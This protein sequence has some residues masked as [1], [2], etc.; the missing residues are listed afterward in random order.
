[1]KNVTWNPT[2][3]AVVFVEQAILE[4]ERFITFQ[5]S[6][7]VIL[8]AFWNIDSSF[9]ESQICILNNFLKNQAFENWNSRDSVERQKHRRTT[10]LQFKELNGNLKNSPID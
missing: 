6:I 2:W 9:S 7:S 1:M 4:T 10:D 8:I 3:Y 5:I